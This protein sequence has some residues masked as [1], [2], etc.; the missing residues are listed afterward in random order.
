[1]EQF[2][3][4][5]LISSYFQGMIVELQT[6]AGREGLPKSKM[7]RILIPIPPLGEQAAIIECVKALMGLCRQ[8]EA[9]IKN[10]R[11]HAENLLQAVL[12]EAFTSV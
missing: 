1:M 10:S 3:H 5:V 11:T 9:G 8:L 7:D 2:V 4:K 12:K 6:G